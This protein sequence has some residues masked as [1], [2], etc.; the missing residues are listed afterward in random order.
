MKKYLWNFNTV[1]S[2][3]REKYTLRKKKLLPSQSRT[4]LLALD[5]LEG[6]VADIVPAWRNRPG[7]LVS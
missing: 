1:N 3:L 7:F 4:V 5:C 6:H 2:V